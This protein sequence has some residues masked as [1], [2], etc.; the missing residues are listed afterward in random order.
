[1]KILLLKGF[2]GSI[3]YGACFLFPIQEIFLCTKIMKIF[4]YICFLKVMVQVLNLV[5]IH[6]KLILG[7]ESNRGKVSFFKIIYLF[8]SVSFISKIFNHRIDSVFAPKSLL[9]DYWNTIRTLLPSLFYF[10]RKLSWPY[11]FW[12]TKMALFR[13]Q[14]ILKSGVRVNQF[15]SF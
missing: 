13:L 4:S 8:A 9:I 1:M 12:N 10:Q 6:L 11:I 15:S 7:L 2:N 3:F 14:I 5:M